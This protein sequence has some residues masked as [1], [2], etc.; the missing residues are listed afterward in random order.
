MNETKNKF[1]IVGNYDYSS[2]IVSECTATT[3]T[4]TF[5]TTTTNCGSLSDQAQFSGEVF[6]Y[7]YTSVFTTPQL[8]VTLA[9][10]TVIA[11]VL[12]SL[13][14]VLVS[15]S[16]VYLLM[17]KTKSTGHSTKSCQEN[18]GSNK[19]AVIYDLPNILT[20]D[21]VGEKAIQHNAAYGVL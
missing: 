1:I 7:Y 18:K 6:R 4:E 3:Y 5:T 12:V 2:V 14:S 20:V 17:K 13:I 15:S 8:G 19:A 10:S 16:V 11:A 21:D 9:V